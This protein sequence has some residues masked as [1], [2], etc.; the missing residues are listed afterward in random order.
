MP[1]YIPPVRDLQFV[2]QDLLQL[3]HAKLPGHEDLDP[4][5]T[6]AILDAAGKLAAEVMAPINVSGD[7]QGCSL[8]NGIVRTPEGFQAAYDALK[9]GAGPPWTV[10]PNMAARACRW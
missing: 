4:D 9:D 10:T 2:L 5:F 3:Q 1:S 8:E 7:R 6:E